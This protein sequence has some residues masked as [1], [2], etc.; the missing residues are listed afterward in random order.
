ML[1]D[2]TYNFRGATGPLGL[3]V[4]LSLPLTKDQPR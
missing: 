4:T 3:Q 2:E 1:L